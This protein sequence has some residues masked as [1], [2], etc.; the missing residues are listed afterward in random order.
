MKKLLPIVLTLLAVTF[1]AHFRGLSI[2][3][4][5][6]DSHSIENNLAVK[7]LSFL[8]KI[9]TDPA[10]SSI[11][12][13][14]RHYRPLTFTTYCFAW[15]LG[16]GATWMFHL[17]KILMHFGVALFLFLIWRDLFSKKGWLPTN[18]IQPEGAAFAIALIFAIHPACVET[19]NYI[20]ATTS[21]QCSLFY[22]A[23][24][25]AF[26]KYRENRTYGRLA[27]V[28]ALFAGSVMTKEEGVTLPAVLFITSF[29]LEE[30]SFN[31]K[32]IQSI[33]DTALF[34]FAALGLGLTVIHMMPE[35]NAKSRGD[36]TPIA[37]FMTQWRAWLWYMRIWFWPWDL[38]A[39]NV[40]FG[41]SDS[42]W[43]DPRVIQALIGNVVLLS[44]AWWKRKEFPALIYGLLWFY[45]AIAPASSIV[46]LAEP[47]NEHR[48][49]LSYVGF[50][51]GSFAVLAW[52]LFEG[53]RP[54]L[55]VRAAR[56]LYA[57]IFIGLFIGTQV[58]ITVWQTSQNLWEDTVA[59]N[60]ASG[61]ALNN[62][63]LIYMQNRQYDQALEM[64]TRC[65]QTWPNY[66]YCPLNKA[67]TYMAMKDVPN[68]ELFIMRA[69]GLD[70]QS[71]YTNYFIGR[72]YE[73]M[74]ADHEKAVG[75]FRKADDLSG[76]R[77][78]DAKFQIGTIYLKM[79]KVDDAKAV[80]S[81][82]I[83]LE[84]NGNFARDLKQ[85]ID[86]AQAPKG[87]TLKHT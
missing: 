81:E 70:P 11:I 40:V 86:H 17:F 61:R 71:T 50:A 78:L 33:K 27:L 29:F 18:K 56:G 25:Y 63:A 43:G 8:P 77:D 24:V 15:V 19:A 41:F 85:A 48:M 4:H 54:P 44:F 16:G 55:S 49:Y 39:D 66:L 45:I 69:Y 13:E 57:L 3:F 9:W 64:L 42:F 83:T 65:E 30:G 22:V 37:Y 52:L 26:L 38:N 12:P 84:P 82:I 60:P 80:L 34:W 32:V 74:K 35:T 28:L 6:D 2:P 36:I 72:F 51:G 58:R 68:A 75:Y 47:V 7:S 76:S 73:E 62:L 67:V 5:F 59:K 20:A 21:L 53:F 23:A 10:T 46:P 79:G 31:K 14:N 87:I 1:F